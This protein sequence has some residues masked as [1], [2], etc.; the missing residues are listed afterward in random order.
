MTKKNQGLTQGKLD[1]LCGIYAII[2]II[3]KLHNIKEQAYLEKIFA[4][5]LQTIEGKDSK[6]KLSSIIIEGLSSRELVKILNF[7]CVTNK[8]T[9]IKGTKDS[10]LDGFWRILEDK[11]KKH[12]CAVL[13]GLSGKHDHWTVIDK[14]TSDGITLL[15][16]DHLKHFDKRHCSLVKDNNNTHILHPAQTYFFIKNEKKL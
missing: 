1:N 2:N 10:S 4:E 13:L 7:D 11:L 16:S 5:I 12:N 3:K 8:I 6:M 14:V 15:D 9:R